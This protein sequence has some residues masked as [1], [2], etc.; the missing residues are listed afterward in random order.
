[1]EVQKIHAG[2]DSAERGRCSLIPP[3]SVGQNED[4]A[5]EDINQEE[6]QN[7]VQL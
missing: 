4:E 6:H 7:T 3:S 2:C 5:K 1:M